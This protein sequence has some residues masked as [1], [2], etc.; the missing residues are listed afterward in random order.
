MSIYWPLFFLFT[1]IPVNLPSFE[2]TIFVS[3][4]WYRQFRTQILLMFESH[5]VDIFGRVSFF[6]LLALTFLCFEW[7]LSL[8]FSLFLVWSSFRFLVLFFLIYFH[9][10][11]QYF[12]FN[13]LY[14]FILI[15]LSYKGFG[16]FLIRSPRPT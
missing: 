15:F 1:N 16:Q 9:Y 10:R 2:P 12:G 4:I 13:F 14:F 11:N 7:L 6:S 8:A 5:P 3:G